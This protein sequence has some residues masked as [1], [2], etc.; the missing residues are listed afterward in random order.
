MAFSIP[1]WL[2]APL[3]TGGSIFGASM[4]GNKLVKSSP[5]ELEQQQLAQMAQTR[6]RGQQTSANLFDMG[7]PAA[8]Q[9]IDYWSAILSGDRSKMTS[10]M[11]P[12]L[13]RIGE[14]YQAAA[15]TSAALNP[16][17]GP[18]PDFLSQQPYSQQRDVST[19]FQQARPEAARQL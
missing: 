10:A 11:G 1:T 8:Q 17:G 18:T 2:R 16:R 9:P 14:G 4:L 13:S 5:S 12:E 3:V 15:R 7:M 6:Q 19:M